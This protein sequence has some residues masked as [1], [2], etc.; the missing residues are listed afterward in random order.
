MTQK[1]CLL[2]EVHELVENLPRYPPVWTE[3]LARRLHEML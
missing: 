3:W 1:G 2:R